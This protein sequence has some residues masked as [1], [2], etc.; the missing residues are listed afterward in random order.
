MYKKILILGA[1]GLIGNN[2][3]RYLV[4]KKLCIY[5]CVR[6]SGKKVG[7]IKNYYYGNL[8]KNNKINFKKMHRIVGNLKPDLVINCLGV[9]KHK[10]VNQNYFDLLNFKLIKLL[11]K[12]K[13]KIINFSTD[14]IFNG[15]NGNYKETSLEYDKSPYAKSKIKA[16]NIRSN[17]LITLRTSAFGKERLTKNGLFEWFLCQ[18]KVFGYKFAYFSGPTCHE[19]AQ[20]IYNHIIIRKKI[21]FG[22]FNIG[23]RG[24]SKYNLLTLTNDIYKKNKTIL[25]NK[26]IKINRTLNIKKFIKKTNYRI[27][28]WQTMIAEMKKFDEKSF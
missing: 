14:C 28:S 22:R 4:A 23:G 3:F 21:S 8:I 26:K 6:N 9:T 20:I 10:S 7:E 16:E 1:N 12:F 27:K 11:L 25:E 18:K 24:I 19:I 15:K 5:P 17:F 2:I 13:V